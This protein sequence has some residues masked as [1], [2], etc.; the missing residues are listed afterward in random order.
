MIS[1]YLFSVMK[2]VRLPIWARHFNFAHGFIEVP[3]KSGKMFVTTNS[4]YD[5]YAEYAKEWERD[6]IPNSGLRGKTV[7]DVGA[8]CGETALLF[9]R[10]RATK[11]ICIE[12]DEYAYDAL[13]VN[14]VMNNWN[15]TAIQDNFHAE[16]IEKFQPDF[17]KI[18][19]E[20]G[21]RELLKLESLP[22][23]VVEVHGKELYRA[24]R[25][26]FPRMRLKKRDRWRQLWIGTIEE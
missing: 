16:Y 1:D 6:Y 15:V 4:F 19:C 10:A 17:C 7:L 12:P 13:I 14:A 24:F 9:L 20:G 22:S 11:V 21:E 26:K 5:F 18:D 8:G 23:M 3:L 2:A 25:R